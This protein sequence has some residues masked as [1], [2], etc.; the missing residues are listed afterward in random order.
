MPSPSSTLFPLTF[1]WEISNHLD[2]KEQ[3]SDFPEGNLAFT[4]RHGGNHT[5]P[6]LPL[7]EGSRVA[8]IGVARNL[9]KH[10]GSFCTALPW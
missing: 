3:R 8:G 4:Q 7:V 5:L 10:L 9:L 1:T 6:V 2:T